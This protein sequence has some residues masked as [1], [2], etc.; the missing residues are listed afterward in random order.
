MNPSASNCPKMN[1]FTVVGVDLALAHTGI[2]A[3]DAGQ[4]IV[5]QATISTDDAKTE[6]ER[7]ARVGAWYAQG[8][9]CLDELASRVVNGKPHTV[10]VAYETRQFMFAMHRQ[11]KQ[12]SQAIV[13]FGQALA[14]LRLALSQIQRP[15]L[16]L[17]IG[18]VTPNRWQASIAHGLPE[19]P[20]VYQQARD[21]LRKCGTPASQRKQKAQV[22]VAIYLRV[23]RWMEDDHQA[24]AAGI[25]LSVSDTLVAMGKDAWSVI[26]DQD[27]LW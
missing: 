26:I 2:V 9:G 3:L 6:Q 19:I 13:S 1:D 12:S 15:N 17:Q 14:A 5:F 11:G 21:R 10:F 22:M 27:H 25:A 20:G 18:A 23:G 16:E 4:Q 8:R 24:D 7:M